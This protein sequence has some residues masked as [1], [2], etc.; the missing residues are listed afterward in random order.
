MS[1]ENANNSSDEPGLRSGDKVGPYTI[2]RKL[3]SGGMADVYFGMHGSLQRPAAIKVLRAALA[4]DEVH[5]QRFMQEARALA[6]LVHSNI[7]QVY[8]VGQEGSVRYIAQEYVPGINL[9]QYLNEHGAMLVRDALSVLL[10]VLA[11]LKKS[12]SA[13]IIHRDIKPDNILLT[14]DGEVKVTDFGLARLKLQDDP[15][16]TRAGTT[17]GTPMYM[18]PEQLQEGSVDVR[19]D[20]YSLGVTLFHMLAGRPPFTGET[21]LAVAMQQVQ[22]QPPKLKDVRSDL[23]DS[24]CELVERLLR[25]QPSERYASPDEVLKSL[26]ES[27]SK[28]LGAMWPEQTVAFPEA[29]SSGVFS[30]PSQATIE[31]QAKLN[32]RK[33]ATFKRAAAWVAVAALGLAAI[34]GGVALAYWRPVP[35]VFHE[36]MQMHYGVTKQASAKEQYKL[37]LLSIDTSSEAPW[38]AVAYFFS[39]SEQSASPS[40]NRTYVGLANLQLARIRARSGK[41]DKALEILNEIRQ[42]TNLPGTLLALTC[43]EQAAIQATLGNKD[44]VGELVNDAK[45]I[46]GKLESRRQDIVN[47]NVPESIRDLWNPN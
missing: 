29:S 18:S 26:R 25:K 32:L 42:N 47:S 3:G 5:L 38:L 24:L 39:P 10:Q 44:A 4:T 1:S 22:A 13:G 15:Q 28:D 40:Q 6:S 43:L 35:D 36:S 2:E 17:L 33:Q 8:D 11:A 19:S 31:M 21:P 45:A 12:S 20:L 7:V 41:S 16:L 46:V 27:R 9:R 34:G 37:A 14:R 30:G 23:P